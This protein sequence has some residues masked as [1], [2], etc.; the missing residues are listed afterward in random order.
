MKSTCYD[1]CT[2]VL[3]SDRMLQSYKILY[4]FN[5]WMYPGSYSTHSYRDC[6]TCTS[7][8]V[9][10]NTLLYS[11]GLHTSITMYMDMVTCSRIITRPGNPPEG[12]VEP[13]W[14]DHMTS[15]ATQDKPVSYPSTLT[16]Y[17]HQTILHR[18]TEAHLMLLCSN[19][20]KKSLISS[21]HWPRPSY[22]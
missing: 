11:I 4:S 3:Y 21:S 10:S 18:S 7:F 8:N 6:C 9:W 5:I 13:V 17:H 15:K 1:V 2:G 14:H 19:G 12:Q 22:A 20:Y 16:K